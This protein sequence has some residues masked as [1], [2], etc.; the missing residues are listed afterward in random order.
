MSMTIIIAVCHYW[1]VIVDL[2]RAKGFSQLGCGHCHQLHLQLTTP[3]SWEHGTGQGRTKLTVAE[4]GF[5]PAAQVQSPSCP[6][7]T[8]TSVP[9]SQ[10]ANFTA[11]TWSSLLH[12][13]NSSCYSS[14]CEFSLSLQMWFWISPLQL[15][16][17]F[18]FYSKGLIRVTYKRL[19]DQE[20]NT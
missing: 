16:W 1:A 15:L 19:K 17:R 10:G 14:C 6:S 11:H 20:T 12:Q 13:Q 8:V 5:N 4:P 9:D 3:R 18:Q 2:T 7:Y